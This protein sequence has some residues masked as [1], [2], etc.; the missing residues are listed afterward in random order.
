MTPA[1]TSNELDVQNGWEEN[2]HTPTG[3]YSFMKVTEQNISW[4]H[5]Y[6]F[7]VERRRQVDTVMSQADILFRFAGRSFWIMGKHLAFRPYL[8][9][10]RASI[11]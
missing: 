6:D 2:T 11:T 7:A 9:Q 4:E 3:R 5:C 1:G 8:P 10:V